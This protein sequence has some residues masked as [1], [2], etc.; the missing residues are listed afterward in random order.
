MTLKDKGRLLILITL[1]LATAPVALVRSQ[2]SVNSPYTRFGT[3]NLVDN[4]LDPRTTAMGGIHYGIQRND[5]INTANPAS[6]AAFDSVSFLFD[7]GLFGIVTD[8]KTDQIK[9]Q[10]SF[11]TLS[12]LL[13]GFPVTRWWKSSFGVLPFSFVG[14]DIYNEEEFQETTTAV[15][16]YKGSGGFNQLYWGNGFRIGKKFSVGFN[17]K[18][19]FGNISR[20]RGVGFPDSLQMKNTRI[21]SNIRP[22]DIYGE[23]GIQYREKLPKD[24]FL[25]VGAT[26]GPEVK[27]HS[28]ASYFAATYFGLISTTALYYDT[29]EFISRKSGSWTL[30][31]R[32]GTGISAG[33]PGI[34]MAGADF[35]WQNWEKYEYYGQSDSLKNRWTVA[36]GGEYI[37]D[38]RSNS[39]FDRVSYR[40]GFHYGKTP[41]YLMDHHIDEIGISFGL[42]LPIKKSK[43]TVNFSASVGRKGTTQDGLI[44]ENFIRFTLGVNVFENWFYKSKYF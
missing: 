30:P 23:V 39:Y 32:I 29:I 9:D 20:I 26:F 2:I 38:S 40:I 42:G 11:I 19:M 33:K 43:S 14:Y 16:N 5:L 15:Y 7:A 22:S 12:H 31:T 24:H 3:G 25:V 35:M 28:N 27:I 41:V 44:Q 18:Y 4:G 36:A 37:P 10:G 6:Y 17:L 1:L 21:S 34:W 13:F 8:L